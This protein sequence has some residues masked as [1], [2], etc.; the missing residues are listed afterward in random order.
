MADQRL[1]Q[2][3]TGVQLIYESC[4]SSYC[5]KFVVLLPPCSVLDQLHKSFSMFK[6]ASIITFVLFS[7]E[8]REIIMSMMQDSEKPSDT[9][10]S[11]CSLN[12]VPSPA[13]ESQPDSPFS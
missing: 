4:E 8:Q 6:S 10:L 11:L 13:T 2:F 5:D 1:H 3:N 7:P 9:S 12:A